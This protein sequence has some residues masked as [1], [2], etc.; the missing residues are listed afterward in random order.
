[1][2]NFIDIAV[3]AGLVLAAVFV[4]AVTLEAAIDAAVH[5]AT[6]VAIL[7]MCV[8]IAV[9]ASRGNLVPSRRRRRHHDRKGPRGLTRACLIHLTHAVR[10]LWLGPRRLCIL[11]GC[12]RLRRGV[13]E[14][15]S[16]AFDVSVE[17]GAAFRVEVFG[18]CIHPGDGAFAVFDR[19]LGF[20]A[21]FTDHGLAHEPVVHLR[22]LGPELLA[23]RVGFIKAAL[24]HE[25]HDAVGEPVESGYGQLVSVR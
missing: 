15:T 8:F 11:A 9:D 24:I 21:C 25:V 13:G 6:A 14:R 7:A 19:A 20:A 5:P 1:M 3:R 23:G 18:M 12:I 17:G 2:R 4:A 22:I 10:A 16:Q